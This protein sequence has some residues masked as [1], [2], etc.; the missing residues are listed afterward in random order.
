[1]SKVKKEKQ[2]YNG[3]EVDSQ[4]EI[5]ILMWLYEL[6]NAGYID[7]IARSYSFKLSEPVEHTYTHNQQMKTKSKVVEKK[8]T[9]LN[10]HIY[11]PEF[12]IE[13]NQRGNNLL[14]WRQSL[15]YNKKHDKVFI[16]VWEEGIGSVVY[17]EVKPKWNANNM[18]RLFKL[19]QKWVFAK[20]GVHINLIIPETLFASTFTPKEYLKT[21]T[22]KI[23]KISW[24]IKTLEEFVEKTCV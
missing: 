22:G 4:E 5:A 18:T 3:I 19:N 20:Y 9:L 1:M 15:D 24:K 2:Y 16:G 7:S 14:V 6:K 12:R 21:P 8:Q 13:L 10:G 11:T 23:R 17:I